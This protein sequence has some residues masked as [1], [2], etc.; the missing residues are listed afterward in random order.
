[1]TWAIHSHGSR[2]RQR[3]SLELLKPKVHGSCLLVEPDGDRCEKP[4][5]RRGVKHTHTEPITLISAVYGLH[6]GGHEFAIANMTAF[7]L[8]TSMSS[9]VPGYPQN[10]R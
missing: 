4:A 3:Q 7:E 2:Y 6:K 10:P 8:L 5:K 9:G 1:M